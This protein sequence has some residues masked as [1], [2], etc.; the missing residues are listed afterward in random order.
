MPLTAEDLRRDDE[1]SRE[2]KDRDGFR[3]R[4]CG[5]GGYVEAAHVFRRELP[6]RWDVDNGLTLCAG[7]RGEETCHSWAHAHPMDF[8]VWAESELGTELFE[9]LNRKAY[10]LQKRVPRPFHPVLSEPVGEPDDQVR[11]A[12]PAYMDPIVRIV[13]A[14][15]LACP[16][17]ASVLSLDAGE[18]KREIDAHAEHM[19]PARRNPD[20][21]CLIGFGGAHRLPDGSEVFERV[22]V[23]PKGHEDDPEDPIAE[24][25]WTP[26]GRW[27][28]GGRRAV[29]AT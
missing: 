5:R 16:C 26:G 7:P 21:T 11:G 17:G 15:Q 18:A 13:P 23:R 1:W 29:R 10:A 6:T 24:W 25:H 20:L 22:C 9:A 4:K 2:V 27:W 8:V 28:K 19:H 14:V 12:D 3:C